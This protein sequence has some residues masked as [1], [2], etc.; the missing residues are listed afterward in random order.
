MGGRA[1][2]LPLCAVVF[3]AHSHG[4]GA[5]S[6]AMSLGGRDDRDPLSL[7]YRVLCLPFIF[8]RAASRVPASVLDFRSSRSCRAGINASTPDLDM[9]V[10]DLAHEHRSLCAGETA[11]GYV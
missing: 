3:P 4:I 2:L 11:E 1:W 9:R 10:R 6:C 7:I 5:M 8:S